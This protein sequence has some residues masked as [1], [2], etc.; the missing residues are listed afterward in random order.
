M[1]GDMLI[2]AEELLKDVGAVVKCQACHAEYVHVEDRKRLAYT[3]ATTAWQDGRFGRMDR[4]EVIRLVTDTLGACS[5]RQIP[6]PGPP[7]APP[8]LGC[9]RRRRWRSRSLARIGKVS[10]R[11]CM[12]SSTK[13]YR[14]L[15]KCLILR[16]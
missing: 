7:H 2:V 10:H 4:Q 11:G 9:R 14:E 6:P 16:N 12:V 3:R 8:P 15:K 13:G 1:K 5:P